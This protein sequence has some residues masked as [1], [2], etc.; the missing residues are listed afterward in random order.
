MLR[1]TGI[2]KRFGGVVALNGAMLACDAGEVHALLGA[3]GSGKS[4]LNKVLTGVVRPDSGQIVVRGESASITGPLDMQRYKIAAVYQELSLIP[5]L[6]VADN[7][8]LSQEPTNRLGFVRRRGLL[9]QARRWVSR[10]EEALQRTFDLSETVE[11][12][13]PSDQQLVEIMKALTRDP[14]ILILDEATASLH[15]EEVQALFRI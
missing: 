9:E 2:H 7:I 15:Y 8:V 12:L 14:D 5:Q 11:N 3:N 4:T 13:S 6:S 10:F 1:M